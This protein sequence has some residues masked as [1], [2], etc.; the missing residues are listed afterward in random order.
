ML[1]TYI[2]ENPDLP[3]DAFDLR[4]VLALQLIEYRTTVLAPAEKI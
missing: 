4:I 2:L 3:Q 1:T